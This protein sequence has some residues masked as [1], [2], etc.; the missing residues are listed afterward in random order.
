[1]S[2]GKWLALSIVGNKA[3]TVAEAPSLTELRE[4]IKD[5]PDLTLF[6]HDGETYTPDPLT[7]ARGKIH[8][9]EA[10]VKLMQLIHENNLKRI[11]ELRAGVGHMLERYGDDAYAR[12]LLERTP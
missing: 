2:D 8:E 10:T 9:L 4:K 12:S 1:M 6:F 5:T 11:Q 7:E 3:T